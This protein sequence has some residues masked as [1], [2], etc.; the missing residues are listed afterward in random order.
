MYPWSSGL[1][2]TRATHRV[3][4]SPLLC[5]RLP[6]PPCVILHNRRAAA[7]QQRAGLPLSIAADCM[8]I[9]SAGIVLAYGSGWKRNASARRTA[10]EVILWRG[11]MPGDKRV[12]GDYAPL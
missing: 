3:K 1:T 6:S 9:V 2:S 11:W 12:L 5:P 7:G 4:P 10:P 8:G